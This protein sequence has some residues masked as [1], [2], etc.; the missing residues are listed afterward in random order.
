MSV[1]ESLKGIIDAKN[2][3]TSL[4]QKLLLFSILFFDSG[5]GLRYH[6]GIFSWI[7]LLLGGKIPSDLIWMMQGA[8]MLIA[9]FLLVKIIFSE[10]SGW[11]KILGISLSPLLVLIFIGI[12]FELL[13]AGLDN[14]ARMFFNISSILTSSLVWGATYLAIAVGLTL[15]YRVQRYGNFAQAEFFIIG[16]YIALT[17]QWSDRFFE[18]VSAP[19]DGIVNW[20]LILFA[21]LIAFFVTGLIGVVIDRLVYYR[22]R[23]KNASPQTMM[24]ASLGVAMILRA[25]VYLRFTAASELFTPDPDW[26]LTSQ[27]FEVPS[28]LMRFRLGERGDSIWDW[29]YQKTEE[30]FT[31][32]APDLNPIFE[33]D[34]VVND[35]GFVYYKAALVLVVFSSVILLYLLMK[36]TR[37]GR[38]MRAVADNPDLAASSGINIE[39]IQRYS[40]FLS[41]GLSGFGGAFFA[42]SVRINPEV[43]LSILLPAF[44]VIV[45][46]TIGS[47]PGAIIG[48]FCVG[49]VRSLSEPILV[50]SG[51]SL[52]RANWSG[53]SEVMPFIFLIVI[54]MLMPKG[55]GD[56]FESWNVDR[57]RKKAESEREPNPKIFVALAFLPTGAFG[58]HNF[59]KENTSRAENQ[60][61]ITI[62]GIFLWL[63]AGW[64]LDA[65]IV[66]VGSEF[67]IN[68]WSYSIGIN[69]G[70]MNSVPWLMA[71]VWL[72]AIFEGSYLLIGKSEDPFEKVL[73]SFERILEPI[74]EANLLISDTIDLAIS[75]INRAT[76]QFFDTIKSVIS[77]SIIVLREKLK[78]DSTN[79]LID[80]LDSTRQRWYKF[81]PYGRESPNGSY[82]IFAL[83]MLLTF[84]ITASLESSSSFTKAMQI[85]RILLLFSIYSLW[86]FSLNIHT[87]LTGMVNFGVIFFVG[88]G[89]VIVSLLTT[90]I[91]VEMNG[92]MIDVGGYGWH[93]IPAIILALLVSAAI[94][95][96]IAY[97]TAEL[98]TDYFAIVTVSLGELLRIT[99]IAEPMLRAGTNTTAIGISRYTLP[100]KGW[101]ESGPS[102]SVGSMLGL[103]N[104]GA[105][106][107]APYV[108]LLGF[109]ALI[110]TIVCW[111]LLEIIFA[112]P[113]SRILR[114]IKEDEEVAQHHGHNVISNKAASLALGAAIAALGGIFWAW[115]N[116]TIHPDNLSPARTTFIIWAAFI[117]GG[118]G[119]NRGMMVGAMVLVVTEF[120]FNALITARGNAESSLHFL[121]AYIDSAFRWLMLDSP[122]SLLWSD[123][124]L[125]H[126]FPKFL[127]DPL[128]VTAQLAYLKLALI[129]LVIIASLLLAEK[130]LVP[131]VPSRPDDPEGVEA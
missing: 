41:A 106:S 19:R 114:A 40:A 23:L 97:P 39:S 4:Q 86:S 62:M 37:L 43:G 5:I 80:K 71:L 90:P 75:S 55:L 109:T 38:R 84:S 96:V 104:N 98:R 105:P 81:A 100:M 66:G 108:L 79:F 46:G 64:A 92:V 107:D 52:G 25:M 8:E 128:S 3:L 124:A 36:K 11:K 59:Y 30:G 58:L 125:T 85:G 24:I 2:N 87:G 76:G 54:L 103:A 116:T 14:D 32:G 117:V 10:L 120:T 35:Y 113:W 72:S 44:A 7:D 126:A 101:W 16:A 95:W 131:E 51:N 15:T 68:N 21:G 42:A 70:I 93:P 17:L 63:L 31:I 112:S 1:G 91:S 67:L 53:F 56:A 48:S 33:W 74:H 83:L 13:L 22:F 6:Q 9:A 61:I 110:T 65:S 123:E 20:N 88:I 119:S 127:D 89:A 122:L 111:W 28:R 99:L 77:K 50:G 60:L 69:I 102:E 29:Q 49:L 82:L 47:I 34:A 130:G 18:G 94:G 121:I 73:D 57:L 12:T 115:M 26:R 27:K 129:G 78:T 118:K 45:L